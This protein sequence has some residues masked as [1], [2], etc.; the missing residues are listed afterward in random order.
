MLLLTPRRLAEVAEIWPGAVTSDVGEP[1][2]PVV[3][4][5]DVSAAL[6]PRD[7]LK[8]SAVA[9]GRRRERATLRTGDVVVVAKG[10]APRVGV[11]GTDTAGAVASANLLI[12]RP[13]PQAVPAVIS[14]FLQTREGQRRLSGLQA[15]TVI[16]S[17]SVAALGRLEIPIPEPHAQQRIAA[18][19]IAAEE[20]LGADERALSLRR[21]LVARI[22]ERV[23]SGASLNDLGP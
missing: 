3:L 6:P 13:G 5:R 1:K 11:A 14:A 12:V 22:T 18:F 15:G 17:L 9:E 21:E 16:Q 4:P 19:A 10:L 7:A 2:V 20:L 8:L 23:F